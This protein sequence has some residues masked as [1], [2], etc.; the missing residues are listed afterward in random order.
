VERQWPEIDTITVQEIECEDRELVVLAR[1]QSQLQTSEV[2][3]TC[4]GDKTQLSVDHRRTAGKALQGVRQGRQARGPL[5]AVPAVEADLAPI[6]DD[7][8]PVAV[9]L[10]FVQPGHARWRLV[11]ADRTAGADERKGLG[12][13]IAG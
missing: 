8:Q 9:E 7:L 11:G 13:A 1:S 3:R 6:L 5:E 2:R 12:H 4:A 10:G